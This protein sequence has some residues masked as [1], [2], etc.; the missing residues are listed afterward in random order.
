M[1]PNPPRNLAASPQ[2]V[3][4]LLQALNRAEELTAALTVRLDPIVQH[5][6]TKT[7][8]QPPLPNTVTSRLHQIGDALQYLLDNIEL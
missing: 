5:A 7:A 8:E 1:E 2:K 4:P 6:P 3:V